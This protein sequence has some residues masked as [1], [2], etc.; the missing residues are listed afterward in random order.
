ML[1]LY[2]KVLTSFMQVIIDPNEFLWLQ[3]SMTAS[4]NNIN[5]DII[6]NI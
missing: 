2:L 4:L 5:T 1:G 3:S 6:I